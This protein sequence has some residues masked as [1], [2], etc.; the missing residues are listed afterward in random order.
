MVTRTRLYTAE[1][2]AAMPG[3]EPWELW[4]GELRKVPGAGTK[5]S[6]L[7]GWVGV[8]ISNFSE[9]DDLGIVTFADGT[10]KL[11]SDPDVVLVPDVAYIRW[12]NVP[13][14]EPP[15]GFF[16]GRPDLAIEMKSPS[17]RRRDIDAKM[18]LYR[19]ARVPLVWWMFPAERFV[20]VYRNG[21]LVATLHDG[22]VLDGED[23]L[24]GFVLPVTDIFERFKRT[25]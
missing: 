3:D 4:Y 21:E 9:P 2:L 14:R 12:E 8:R 23:I 5:A 13:N 7:A 18:Q 6:A 16:P 1:E 15:D 10:F 11:L 24:P 22:D 25:R 17:D 20:E 19:D